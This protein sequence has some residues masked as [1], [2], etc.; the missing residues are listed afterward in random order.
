MEGAAT[1]AQREDANQA[2]SPEGADPRPA[3][4][5]RARFPPGPRSVWSG[6]PASSWDDWRWQ[7]RER[8]TRL[9]QLEKVIRVTEEERRA[10]IETDAEFHM[11]ITPYY[12]ALMDPEDPACPVRLQSVPTMGEL[13]SSP[14]DLEDPLAEDRDMPVPGI[15]HRYPDRVLFYTTHNCPVYCRHCTRKRKVAD[16]TSAAARKQV[17]DG[18]DYIALHREIRDVVI[19]GGDPLS[20]SDER[21]D[22]VLGRLRAIPHVEIF[23][24]GTRN[25]VTLPQRI[26]DDLVRM[27]RRHQPVYVNTHFNHPKECTAEAFEA[28]RRL[29]D[30]GCAI[31]NQMVLLKGI[32]DDPR[33]VME[34]NHKLLLMRVR[35][36]YIYQCD[37][38]KGISHFRTPIEAGRK[39]IRALRGHTSGLAVPYFVVDA[40]EGGGKIPVN[41]DYVVR[42]EGK[43][44]VLRN[45]AGK[46]YTYFEP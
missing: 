6:V 17:E 41:P 32:N 11:G 40:P 5:L 26:T 33:T 7:Q 38:A 24:L 20:L 29:A 13:Y 22:Y 35:P 2:P 37:L 16:P 39:I 46:E 14:A 8:I 42:H 12:A 44:W 28:A 3:A 36:Y 30:G 43:K 9:E 23:R 4:H 27:L 1:T 45:Y 25:L 31:G 15:T 10:C 34:L 18:L 19:S 21:L